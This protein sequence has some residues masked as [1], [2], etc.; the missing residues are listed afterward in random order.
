MKDKSLVEY[1]QQFTEVRDGVGFC[2]PSV[3]YRWLSTPENHDLMKPHG[4]SAFLWFELAEFQALDIANS[5]NSLSIHA[6]NFDAWHRVLEGVARNEAFRVYLEFI[7]SNTVVALNLPYSIKSRFY[8]AIAHLSH[9][10]NRFVDDQAWKESD[11]PT[12]QEINQEIAAKVARNW[13]GWRRVAK[14]LELC[15]STSFRNNSQD[16][17][18]KYNHRHDMLVGIQA[19]PPVE[20]KITQDIEQ[21]VSYTF[22]G[23]YTM[24]LSEISHLIKIEFQN[25]CSAYSKLQGLI[26]E[27]RASIP[28]S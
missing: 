3:P 24:E 22:G 26:N 21:N 11:L 12:D 19:T 6:R 1:Y 7:Q 17:R 8:Y 25:F 5:I 28:Y 2:G 14:E 10:A 15:N 23:T 4:M 16:F 9:Q 18:N 20:R 13:K 27:Q